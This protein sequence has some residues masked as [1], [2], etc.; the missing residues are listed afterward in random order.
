MKVRLAVLA[1][2]VAVVLGAGAPTQE[3]SKQG[4]KPPVTKLKND[5][6]SV[7]D[8]KQQIQKKLNQTKGHV[9]RVRG[10]IRTIDA[11]IGS[12]TDALEKTAGRLDVNRQEQ[13]RLAGDLEATTKRLNEVREQVR[14]RLRWIYTHESN[15]P[16]LALFKA[17]DVSDVAARAYLLQRI[18]AADRKLFNDYIELRE[19]TA[20]K[21]ARQ[22]QLV[23][24]IA[25][26]KHQQEGQKQDLAETREDKAAALGDLVKQQ[27]D[28]ERLI[29]KLDAEE[30]AIAARIAAYYQGAGKTSGLKPFTGRFSRPVSGPI[31]SGYGMRNHPILRRRRL[32]AGID[33]GAK[34]GTPIQAAAEGV[35]IL[36][37]YS[38]GYGNQV[39]IDH[40]GG[41]STLY[42][43]CSRI[44]VSAGQRITR[45]QTIA[46]VGSTGLAT[47]PHLHWEVRVNGRPVNPLAK[48]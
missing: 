11:R 39:V 32:H 7:R 8:K 27:K 23:T 36:S 26:L 20:N 15:S 19:M 35:V 28:L 1:A 2:F 22:D 42:G 25:G 47:G 45:G 4:I 40:G 31:T 16:V 9:R 34:R 6:G 3:K 10:D 41:I 24:E 12:V 44:L 48:L 5:L 29:R 30:A 21:K 18:A 43:H 38:D 37:T 17:K 33:F 14:K 46:L 13:V